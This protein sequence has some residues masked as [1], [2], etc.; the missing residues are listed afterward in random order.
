MSDIDYDELNQISD[1]INALQ[2][3][4]VEPQIVPQHVSQTVPLVVPQ[5]TPQVKKPSSSSKKKVVFSKTDVVEDVVKK[6]TI[7]DYT[8]PYHTLYLVI[9]LIVVGIAMWFMTKE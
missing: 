4:H 3:Q 9:A 2:T 8:I 5:N 7:G 1:E 6:L